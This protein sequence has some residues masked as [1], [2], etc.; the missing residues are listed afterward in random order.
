MRIFTIIALMFVLITASAQ[1]TFYKSE[2]LTV[3]YKSEEFE[4]KTDVIVQINPEEQRIIIH[5]KEL[6][7]IDYEVYDTEKNSDRVVNVY[8]YA[9]D[10]NYKNIKLLIQFKNEYA[11]F[12]IIYNDVSYAYYTKYIPD[13][14]K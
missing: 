8:C 11:V 1:D 2:S 12:A 14:R 6:Q 10:T 9:T 7:I 5:S 4:Q 3:I 13:P